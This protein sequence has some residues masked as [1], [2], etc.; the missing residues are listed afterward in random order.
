K[1]AGYPV[2]L[3]LI[4]NTP[5]DQVKQQYAACDIGV[6]QVLYGW[7]GKV[8]IELMAMGKPA[9]C[10]I[11]PELAPYRQDLPIVNASPKDLTEKLKQLVEH[12]ELRQNLGERGKSY[13]E[14]YHGVKSIVDQCLE[15]YQSEPHAYPHGGGRQPAPHIYPAANQNSG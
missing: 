7:H 15:I 10:Y 6:D 2:E 14:K 9:V 1:E 12:P 8:S 13:A 5:F 3:V 11:D 4:E